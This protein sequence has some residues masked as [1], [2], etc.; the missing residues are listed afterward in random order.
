[1]DVWNKTK[2]ALKIANRMIC[3]FRVLNAVLVLLKGVQ[4]ITKNGDNSRNAT[5]VAGVTTWKGRRPVSSNQTTHH[6]SSGFP[7]GNALPDHSYCMFQKSFKRNLWVLQ[8]VVRGSETNSGINTYF[9]IPQKII[10]IPR[11]IAKIFIRQLEM[12][13]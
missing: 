12:S 4:R 5:L 11:N 13:E 9:Q 7:Q 6:K 10:N 8:S 1:M 2:G 3:V